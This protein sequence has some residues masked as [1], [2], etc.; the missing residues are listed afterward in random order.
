MRRGGEDLGAEDL[1]VAGDHGGVRGG[2]PRASTNAG[3]RVLAGCGTGSVVREGRELA[4]NNGA[5]PT[6][7]AIGGRDGP[8]TSWWLSRSRRRTGVAKGG[9]PRKTTRI[10]GEGGGPRVDQTWGSTRQAVVAEAPMT[11]SCTS[12]PLMTTKVGMVMPYLEA[13]SMLSWV[14]SFTT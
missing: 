6:A 2:G 13:V 10:V 4:P 12:P 5:P 3:S 7:R 14:V 1:A 9:D 8:R 11:C